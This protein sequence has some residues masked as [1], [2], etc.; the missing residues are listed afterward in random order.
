MAKLKRIS[1]EK[2]KRNY[3]ILFVYA[4]R[5]RR[6]SWTYRNIVLLHAYYITSRY[7]I[8]LHTWARR[9]IFTSARLLSIPTDFFRRYRIPCDYLINTGFRDRHSLSCSPILRDF[10]RPA[11]SQSARQTGRQTNKQTNRQTDRQIDRQASRPR[12]KRVVRSLALL[13]LIFVRPR[14]LLASRVRDL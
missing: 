10:S 11:T 5:R 8:A 14:R 4:T 13:L 2:K 12:V 1:H 6:V 9:S 3:N 7:N